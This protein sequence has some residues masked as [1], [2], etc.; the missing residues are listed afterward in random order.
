MKKKI[1]VS[2]YRRQA[3]ANTLDFF[4]TYFEKRRLVFCKLTTEFT[5]NKVNW[6]LGC[7]CNLFFRGIV[8]DFNDFDFIVEQE[9]IEIIQAVMKSLDA[10]LIATGGNG[11]C[12]SDIYLHYILDG[13][14]VDIIS[15]FRLNTFG[16]SFYYRYSNVEVELVDLDYIKVPLISAEALFILYGMM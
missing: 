3:E 5:K 12:E 13:C 6:A 2:S 7:S 4:G 10:V 1:S 9:S 14:D 16:T 8:D 15:G 11:F